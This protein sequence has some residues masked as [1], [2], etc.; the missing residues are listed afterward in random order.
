MNLLRVTV[1]VLCLGFGITG[2]ASDPAK[3]DSRDEFVSDA[4]HDPFEPVNRVVFDVNDFF[5]R[6]LFRPLAEMYR[7]FVPEF[8]RDRVGGIIDNMGEPVVFANSLMQGRATD[9]GITLGRLVVNSTAGVGGMWDIAGKE[10]GWK[11]TSADFG[12]TLH[13]WG[14]GQ[15]PYLVLPLFGPSTVRDGIGM[16]VDMAMTPWGYIAGIGPASTSNAYD[17]V[18]TG[19]G[20]LVKRERHIDDIDELK[21][22]SIDFYAQMRSVYLQYRNKRLGVISTLPTSAAYEE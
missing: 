2:C 12:Q 10:I 1:L 4:S 3:S 14:V 15:G 17:Y 8:V 6:L 19:V 18:S 21:K 5:D 11:S 20:A 13:T 22:G 7:F 16:G 9:A